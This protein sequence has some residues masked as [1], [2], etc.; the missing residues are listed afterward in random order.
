MPWRSLCALLVPSAALAAGVGLQRIFEGPQPAGDAALRWLLWSTG[1]GLAV[2]GIC[3]L[4]LRR[5]LL[6]TAYGIVAP[7]ATA[8]MVS[9]LW[10][11]A[12]PLR[13]VIY[14]R[15]EAACRASGRTVC[16]AAEFTSRCA[17]RG[18]GLGEP[19][20][21]LCGA[22]GCTYRWIYAGPFRSPIPEPPLL[23]SVVADPAGKGLRFALLRTSPLP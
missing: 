4:A 13:E 15:R 22:E 9:A 20:Q 18:A 23:C 12:L 1:P 3:G 14:D 16:S 2:G 11:A 7:W 10:V 6:W 19:Q 8:L 17:E 5:R 21:K